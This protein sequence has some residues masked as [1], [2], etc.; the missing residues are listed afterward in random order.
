MIEQ[1]TLEWYEAR[2]RIPTASNC[3]RIITPG[4]KPCKAETTRTYMLQL[5]AERLLGVPSDDELKVL[6]MERGKLLQGDAARQ[7]SEVYGYELEPGG[8]HV[9]AYGGCSPD[10]LIKGRREA[11][12]IKCP[13]AHT[14]I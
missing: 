9:N 7:F 3:H 2:L 13:A 11:V 8:F 12:E 6:M 4:G 10:A 5:I 1:N 14:L